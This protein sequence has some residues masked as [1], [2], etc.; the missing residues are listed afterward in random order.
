MLFYIFRAYIHA[1]QAHNIE[2][3]ESGSPARGLLQARL[4]RLLR[5][6]K[7]AYL[8]Q[9]RV[10]LMYRLPRSHMKDNI[11]YASFIT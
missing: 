7:R 2:N 5:S 6:A 3:G 10:D 4:R 9:E 1:Y 11:V 8:V